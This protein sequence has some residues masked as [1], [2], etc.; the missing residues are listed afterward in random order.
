[1]NYDKLNEILYD[2]N[3]IIWYLKVESHSLFAQE[4]QFKFSF[5]DGES[6]QDDL[7]Y[8]IYHVLESLEDNS[9]IN[10]LI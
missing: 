7:T 9:L 3:N 4:T 6:F 10:A 5:N 8:D 1:M 2:E